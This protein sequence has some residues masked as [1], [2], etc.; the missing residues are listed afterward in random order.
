MSPPMQNKMVEILIEIIR[1][2][3]EQSKREIDWQIDKYEKKFKK[4]PFV[5][6]VIKNIREKFNIKDY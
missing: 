2:L 6:S 4:N 5:L 3:P 1:N